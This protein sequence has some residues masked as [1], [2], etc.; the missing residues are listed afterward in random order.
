[1]LKHKVVGG[2]AGPDG[3]KIEI[4][5]SEGGNKQTI[6]CDT[7]LVSTGRRPYTDGLQLDKAGLSTDKFGRIETN[8]HW[9]T[10][11]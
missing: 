6:E 2:K 8:E 11:V 10:K 3:C 1:M 4:E 7:V 9:Q 5:A